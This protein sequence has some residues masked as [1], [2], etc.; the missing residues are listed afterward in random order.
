[1][2]TRSRAKRAE[3]LTAFAAL[4]ASTTVSAQVLDEVTV[5]AQRAETDL[6]TTPL[7]VSAVSE[8]RIEQLNVADIKELATFVPNLTVIPTFAYGSGV[9]KITIRGIGAG[10]LP[11]WGIAQDS[12][13]ATYIDGMYYSRNP[14]SILNLS[15]VENVEVLRGPQGTLFGRNTTGGAI[16]YRTYAASPDRLSGYAEAELGSYNERNIKAGI[17]V[18]LGDAWAVRVA[19]ADLNR[20]GQIERGPFDYGGVNSQVGRIAL[21]GDITDKLTTDLG[22]FYTKSDTNGEAQE[23]VAFNVPPGATVGRQM[24][25]L[26]LA[27]QAQGEAPIGDNDPRIVRG[28]GKLPPYCIMDDINPYTISGPLCD[29]HR[30]FDLTVATAKF[31]YQLNDNIKA[32]SLTGFLKGGSNSANDAV[33][34]GTW[35]RQLWQNFKS[36]QQEFQVNF[37]YDRW[38]AVA[39]LNY[40]YEDATEGED[41]YEADFR[42]CQSY[43]SI[44]NGNCFDADGN[45]TQ[46]FL[47]WPAM[48]TARILSGDLIHRR[49]ENYWQKTNSIAAFAQATYHLTNKWDVTG[50]LRY[51]KD[52]KR[53]GIEYLPNAEYEPDYWYSYIDGERNWNATDYRI[54]TQ[55]QLTD[56][57]MVYVSRSKAYKAGLM[58][59]ASVERTI[60]NADHAVELVWTD[61]E[62]LVSNEIGI[63]SEWFDKRLRFNATYF[64]MVWGNRSGT[65]SFNDE[66][67]NPHFFSI[68]EADV[69]SKG[70][71][72]EASFAITQSLLWNGSLS[73]NKTRQKDDP[74]FVLAGNAEDN[75]N[76]GLVHTL[77][78]RSGGT[79][80]SSLNYS[81]TGPVYTFDNE[82]GAEDDPNTTPGYDFTSARV[83]YTAASGKWSV[84]VACQNLLDED[85]SYGRWSIGAFYGGN[86]TDPQQEIRARPRT[87]TA[88]FRYNL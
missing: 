78:F 70:Y 84:G 10:G 53:G 41:T 38:N 60:S 2:N 46:R 24:L 83:T 8:Q 52:K 50:G 16:S 5:T 44:P 28:I 19:A 85:I 76:M 27:L 40:F 45:P 35:A 15:E 72:I 37:N 67:G 12:A 1:M 73:H 65:D 4:A 87:F 21:H 43:R 20:D 59:D 55:Y 49:R 22:V 25:A 81:H 6:Q 51:T 11:S 54:A 33:N 30:R 7:A 86:G 68:N 82:E 69:T 18:P 26:S 39:G 66:N 31:N 71:E 14:G 58:D 47:D 23:F 13:V 9:P 77:D 80:T 62:D 17:N 57:F 42:P 79:L 56:D 32:S 3:L 48:E 61:P 63:R 64:D 74:T 34:I 75:W 29:T 36:A 88:T